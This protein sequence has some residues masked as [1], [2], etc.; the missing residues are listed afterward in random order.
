MFLSFILDTKINPSIIQSSSSSKQRS[1]SS[2][3][4]TSASFT[5]IVPSYMH[6]KLGLFAHIFCM[7]VLTHAPRPQKMNSSEAGTSF[8]SCRYH[9]TMPNM[10]I[11][12][13][14]VF[15]LQCKRERVN[16]LNGCLV[17]TPRSKINGTQSFSFL[18]FN[19]LKTEPGLLA[20]VSLPFWLNYLISDTADIPSFLC[21]RKHH[22]E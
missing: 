6:L 8:H 13:L 9:N 4:S 15:S 1:I 17:N 20:F 7:P 19:L 22:Q 3:R 12:Y 5:C 18:H 2:H 10:F 21:N 11:R 16:V 14:S